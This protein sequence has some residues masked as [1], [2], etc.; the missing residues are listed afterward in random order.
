MTSPSNFN[1]NESCQKLLRSSSS[2]YNC[3]LCRICQSNDKNNLHNVMLKATG[4]KMKEYASLNLYTKLLI[5]IILIQVTELMH[6]MMQL[7]LFVKKYFSVK[8][9]NLKVTLQIMSHVSC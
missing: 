4:F 1:E 6:Y 3:E 7:K 8:H 9:G 2:P 5:N